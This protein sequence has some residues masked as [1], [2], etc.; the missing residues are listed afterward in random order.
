[1]GKEY[2]QVSIFKWEKCKHFEKGEN[3]VIRVEIEYV[4]FVH[5]VHRGVETYA[6][7]FFFTFLHFFFI[8]KIDTGEYQS[9]IVPF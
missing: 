1:M 8:R 7:F 5:M 3:E 4:K 9:M 6:G 2:S